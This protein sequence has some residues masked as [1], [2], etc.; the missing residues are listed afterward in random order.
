MIKVGVD[1]RS[2]SRPI[3]G[4]G[5]YTYDMCRQLAQN[6]ELELRLYSPAPILP[7]YR[8]PF[9]AEQITECQKPQNGLM[10]QLWGETILPYWAW[11]DQVDILWG[12]S[13]RLPRIR[14][15]QF[16]TVVTIHDL[17]WKFAGETMKPLSRI[18]ERIQMPHA[19]K[20]ADRVVISSTST[21]TDLN[22]VLNVNFTKMDLVYPAMDIEHPADLPRE[23]P[24]ID[25]VFTSP[26]FILF[27]GTLE[28][29]K[30]L[31]RLLEA[32]S[33]LSD[34]LKTEC[35]LAIVG[36]KGWGGQNLPE[37]IANLSL[38]NHVHLMGYQNENSLQYLYSKAYILAMPSTYEGF[39][40]PI[41]EAMKYSVPSIAG[42]NS[43]MV[44]VVG[45]TGLLVDADDTSALVDA[46][47]QLLSNK[48][49]YQ[50]LVE[51]CSGQI[52]K[53]DAQNSA[54][55]LYAVFQKSLGNVD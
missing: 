19:V 1:A 14:P 38:E 48:T 52:I 27:V 32:Y 13:H 47:S 35:Q 55:A 8:A 21:R 30:N 44:E 37:V 49:L 5:R 11:K 24:S 53:F 6:P 33:D 3:T 20:A 25:D 46:I 2:L 22:S 31:L 4:V 42:D 18:L 50:K 54:N 40:I 29:R 16:K 34:A 45:D 26:K 9:N 7:E 23:L 41:A 17:V 10:R 36:G 43:S 51:N 28:P 12:P 39:G 15:K